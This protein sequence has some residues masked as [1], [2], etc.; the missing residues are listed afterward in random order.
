MLPALRLSPFPPPPPRALPRHV[1]AEPCPLSLPGKGCPQRRRRTPQPRGEEAV[2]RREPRGPQHAARVIG[3]GMETQRG[4]RNRAPGRDNCA[5][6]EVGYPGP[7]LVICIPPP[8]TPQ[9]KF[10]AQSPHPA[11]PPAQD[12]ALPFP[13]LAPAQVP[14]HQVWK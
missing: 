14:A 7:S 9:T 3:T 13:H 5:L 4:A 12:N 2:R 6:V 11:S 1:G 8:T 10:S